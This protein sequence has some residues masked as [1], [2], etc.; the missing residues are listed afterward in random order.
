M[1]SKENK[2]K[3]SKI[4]KNKKIKKQKGITLVALIITVVVMLILAGVAISAFITDGGIFDKFK[5][6]VNVYNEGKENEK[7]QIDELQ[8]ELSRYFFD[9]WDG[10]TV[11]DRFESGNGTIED[12]YLIKTA[13]Q[14]I[15]FREQVNSGVTFKDNYILLGANIELNPDKWVIDNNNVVFNKNAIQWNPIGGEDKSFEGN[16]NGDNYII[17][18]IYIDN[19]TENNRALFGKNNGVIENLIVE[20]SNVKGYINSS[21]VV[22]ENYG[23]I[24]NIITRDSTV[25]GYDATG[26]ICGRNKGNIGCCTNYANISFYIPENTEENLWGWRA[27]GIC[28]AQ[29]VSGN[30]ELNIKKCIN[31]GYIEGTHNVGGIVGSANMGNISLC[32]NYGTVKTYLSGYA[33]QVG[34]GIIGYPT[35]SRGILVIEN[36]YNIGEIIKEKSSIC[37]GGISGTTGG[38]ANSN[39]IFRNRYSIGKVQS[40]GESGAF[41]GCY[42]TSAENC[43]VT[44]DNCYWTPDCGVEYSSYEESFRD[45][46]I[47][48]SGDYKELADN[49]G[50]EFVYDER[51]GYPVLKWQLENS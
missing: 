32:V 13:P 39:T 25:I 48:I 44:F 22:G 36:S 23:K 4:L 28:G 18:G 9:K 51:K 17:S 41:I 43:M 1:R 42:N 8:K 30:V 12:P 26:G 49:L 37:I 35:A 24:S 14:L 7:E 29:Q 6:A 11:A 3:E 2:L 33:G 47:M 10:V 27:G 38:Y 15:Y 5:V 19:V 21:L 31:Y 45:Q 34:G 50:E 16:F 46:I 40:G 20:N